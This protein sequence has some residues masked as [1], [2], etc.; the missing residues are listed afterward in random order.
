MAVL[1][2]LAVLFGGAVGGAADLAVLQ[3][4][5]CCLA[6]LFGGAAIHRTCDVS[7][8]TTKELPNRIYTFAWA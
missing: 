2:H 1:R 7:H 6:V 8:V 5:R 4:W 3:I